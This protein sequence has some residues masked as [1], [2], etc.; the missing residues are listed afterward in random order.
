MTVVEIKEKINKAIENSAGERKTTAV[1]YLLSVLHN[2]KSMLDE[3]DNKPKAKWEETNCST[4]YF[5]TLSRCSKC[6]YETFPQDDTNYCGG[7]GARMEDEYE[8]TK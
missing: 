1:R 5:G 4:E 8:P 7:C 2:I 6:G 3:L